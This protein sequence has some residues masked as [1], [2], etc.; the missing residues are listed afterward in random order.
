MTTDTTTEAVEA[1]A[2]LL[3]KDAGDQNFQPC[4]MTG[5]LP[6]DEHTIAETLRAIAAE[7]DA[8]VARVE[9]LEDELQR[10]ATWMMSCPPVS[11][12]FTAVLQEKPHD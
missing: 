11:E 1:L 3:E 12:E 9:R 7:R 6:D 2:L 5:L 10:Y 8:L 4:E